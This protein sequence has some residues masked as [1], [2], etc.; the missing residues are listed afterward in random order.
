MPLE[1]PLGDGA[2]GGRLRQHLLLLVT[3][4]M[5]WTV[6]ILLGSSIG[7]SPETNSVRRP[8]HNLLRPRPTFG[9]CP[10]GTTS[11]G[12]VKL[13]Q[14]SCQPYRACH[15]NR[16]AT[17]ADH[18]TAAQRFATAVRCCPCSRGLMP[19]DARSYVLSSLSRLRLVGYDK[20]LT[21]PTSFA[22]C[23]VVVV[24]GNPSPQSEG[25]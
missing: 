22:P 18:D 8:W 24:V 3:S 25:L 21:L 13:R 14:E 16:E 12:A 11:A 23:E 1:P 15:T 17:V 6:V 7:S 10:V 2:F 9:V 19:A 20:A 5:R 4:R